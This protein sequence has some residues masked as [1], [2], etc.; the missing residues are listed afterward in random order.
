MDN[1]L[2][3]E[4]NP[5]GEVPNY[6]LAADNH[7]I[8]NT[9]GGSW[10]DPDT[11]ST[12][13]SNS[14]KFIATSI[15]SGADS[16]YNSAATVGSW[17]GMSEGPHDTGA[18]IAGLDDDL[19][20]YYSQNRDSVD[21][22]GFVLASFIPGLGG[23]KLLNVG[24]NALK[25][26]MASGAIGGNLARA[27]GLLVPETQMYVQ[28][29]A[30]EISAASGAVSAINAN[31]VRALGSGVYKN[32]LEGAAFEIAVQATMFKSPILDQQ[33]GWDIAK[34]VALGAAVGGVIG[35]AIDGARSIYGVRKI[36][37]AEVRGGKPFSDRFIG[38]EATPADQKI[39]LTAEARDY[40]AVPINL[41]G[42]GYAVGN[43]N[44]QANSKLYANAVEKDNNTIRASIN[45][46]VSGGDGTVGNMV[47]DA[48]YNAPA[49]QMM[50]TMLHAA[51]ISTLGGVSK[52]EQLRKKALNALDIEGV[53]SLETRYV[54]L[55]G[56]GA[57]TVTDAAPIISN[58]AD[59]V[60]VTGGRSTKDAVL[61]EVRGYKFN[62]K[63]LWDSAALT[64]K[65]AHTTAE[66]RFIWATHVLPEVKAGTVIHANDIPLLERV[67]ADIGKGKAVDYKIQYADGSIGTGLD[68]T[69]L[70]KHLANTKVTLADSLLEGMVFKGSQPV[71]YGTEAIAKIVNVRK[72]FLE[73]TQGD[74]L[75]DLYARQA[76]NQ[77]HARQL[78]SKG[79]RTEADEVIDT[80]FVPQYAKIG[81]KTQGL[82]DVN[83]NVVDGMIWI[84]Q[85][86]KLYQESADRVFAKNAGSDINSSALPISDSVLLNANLTDGGAGLV[87]FAN[88]SYGSL[89]SY[90]QQI[91]ANVTRPL[92]EA[93]RKATAAAFEGPLVAMGSKREAAI[94]FDI[95][96]NRIAST[97]EQ[98]VIDTAG[99]SGEQYALISKKIRD[100]NRALEEGGENIAVPSLQRGAPEFIPI[101]NEETFNTISAHIDREGSRVQTRKEINA[102]LGKEDGKELD[103]FRPLRPSTDDYP[104][105]AF[106]KDQKVT[107]AGHTTMIHANTEAELRALVDK[108]P[109]DKGYKVI[110][111]DQAEEYYKARGE[112]EYSRTLNENYIDSDLK[113]RGINSQFFTKTDPQK[114]VDD[115]L[116]YHT[117]ADDVTA[118]ELVRMKYQ[119]AF[120]W[121]E[122]QGKQFSS[123]ESSRYGNA[124]S[125]VEKFGKNPYT[126]YTKTAL[127]VSKASEYSLL[128][129]ANKELD[130]A[131]SRV[132][133]SVS[134]VFEGAKS[135]AQLD[136]INQILESH[137]INS[138]YNS[139]AADALINHTAPKAVLSKFV[140]SSNAILAKFTLML[141]PLNGVNNA[142]GANI[143]RFTELKNIDRAIAEGNT[144]VAGA[145]AKQQRIGLP[146]VPPDQTVQSSTKLVGNAIRNFFADDGTLLAQYQK[147]GLVKD[148]LNQFR[149]MLDDFTLR[150]TESVSDIDRRIQS[151]FARAKSMTDS[152]LVAGEKYTGNKFF[153]QFNRFISADVMRQKTDAAEALGLLTPAESKAYRNTFVNRVEGNTIASQRPV[154]F[155]GPIGQA[156]G[157]FQ[158]YQFNLMQQLFR[159]VGEGTGK[160]AAML[161]GLQG[162]MYGL[163]GLPAFNA[164]NTHVIGNLSGNKNHTDLYDATYGIAGKTAG[165][166]LMYGI[167]SS[168]IQTNLYSRGDI[169]P[170]TLTIIPNQIENIPIVAAYSKV[171]GNLYETAGKI[172]GGGNLWESILQGVEHNG[173]SRPLAGLAQTLQATTGNGMVFST[174]N[175]GSI[176]GSNDL[177][178]FATL[179]RLAGGRPLDE[180]IVNDGMYRIASYE[181]AQKKARDKLLE[182][183]KT[184]GIQG[185]E[186]DMSSLD[187]FSEAYAATGGKQ[188]QFN[189]FMLGAYKSANTSQSQ[190]ILQQLQN[191]FNQKMQIL[192]GGR[193]EVTSG[194]PSVAD[195]V[196]EQEMQMGTQQ[197]E[198]E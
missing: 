29:A 178:S 197:Y 49:P 28:L 172:N 37:Q 191:P 1:L 67:A 36:V 22:A 81:Y 186:A 88:G 34:N 150:G 58:I 59:T 62:T 70:T 15:L 85:Q 44:V 107:G 71:E 165:D 159:Y 13:F 119:P 116:R 73:G 10:F 47:A 16:L 74:E 4:L 50:E 133:G 64:G 40:R 55:T 137:G 129:N 176:I 65:T 31:T 125:N 91:G 98:Y 123:V 101:K 75:V 57:G 144:E 109:T 51:D 154:M 103:I 170:R 113:S 148:T 27:T 52:I 185:Q 193:N 180:A 21:L 95:I 76:A 164:I 138:G 2:N 132:Y 102:A 12:K 9:V 168:I 38:A 175:K 19:G 173:I 162:T 114:I 196:Q 60:K 84:K 160:D 54:K 42:E 72:G 3:A 25:V 134:K 94:E 163:N 68:A 130:R 32:V 23:I 142:I 20:A 24:Q 17:A 41:E 131:V 117:R 110:Y 135:P 156:V 153:E 198:G 190:K 108:V 39:I 111:K 195:D 115:I 105:F 82:E 63:E 152:A 79:L 189:K 11:W 87:S 167:P 69:Q 118:V 188:G 126:D 140:R 171:F 100:Y 53:R 155:Q 106:V 124:L 45:S 56:E 61:A 30:R 127:D 166:F 179:S 96:N 187:Q 120:D 169:N 182:T 174:S 83:G 145:L 86:Q 149:D 26:G 97:T 80:A 192:M 33:D 157:L 99:Q 78:V 177:V 35:G 77:S 139:A 184:T 141:D 48:L 5:T 112:F 143:L 194:T 104:F 147:E 158:S 136:E 122:D 146:G 183:V 46:L 14:G 18:W 151:G 6:L 92:K 7:N 128:Y 66:A 43:S 90:M 93:Y 8:G 181:A 89:G 161:L 121:L